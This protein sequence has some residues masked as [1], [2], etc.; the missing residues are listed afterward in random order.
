[1]ETIPTSSGWSLPVF[2]GMDSLRYVMHDG[3][4]LKRRA[5]GVGHIRQQWAYW[6]ANVTEHHAALIPIV[7]GNGFLGFILPDLLNMG[8]V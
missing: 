8:A 1:M 5:M 4:L 7:P 6:F 3:G 2:M